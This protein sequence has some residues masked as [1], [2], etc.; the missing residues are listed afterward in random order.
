MEIEE[1]LELLGEY[2]DKNKVFG[3]V[4]INL[5]SDFSGNVQD[6]HDTLLFNFTDK[7]DLIKELKK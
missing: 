2:E 3:Y 5:F 7:E 1:I 4:R 6:T